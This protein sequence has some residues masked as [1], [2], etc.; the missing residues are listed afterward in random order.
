[1]VTATAPRT[2]RRRAGLAPDERC[3][4]CGEAVR[5]YSSAGHP[6]CDDHGLGPAS[7]GS[8][9]EAALLALWGP[10]PT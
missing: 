7:I 8:P 6:F 2:E 3:I 5:Y 4:V 9:L 1:M 10:P